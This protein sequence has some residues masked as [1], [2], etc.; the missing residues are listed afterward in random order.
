MAASLRGIR[1]SAET[2]GVSTFTV[3]RLIA[4]GLIKTVHIG[5][6]VLISEEE[7]QR[8]A[9]QGVGNRRAR[10]ETDTEIATNQN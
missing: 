4:R 2:L 8:V 3:R 10:T 7:L 5:S 9:S 1:V 6:R